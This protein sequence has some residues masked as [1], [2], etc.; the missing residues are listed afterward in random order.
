[1]APCQLCEPRAAWTTRSSSLIRLRGRA[2]VSSLDLTRQGLCLKKYARP[3]T[4]M[5]GPS[6][7]KRF[8]TTECQSII[9]GQPPLKSTSSCTRK[10]ENFRLPIAD[11]QL[12]KF[13]VSNHH[14]QIGNRQ[15][16]IGNNLWQK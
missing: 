10:S 4:F 6:S 9:H 2:P 13:G 3:Y 8:S 11:C 7:G 14:L 12:K 16:P 15:L 1:M 5:A